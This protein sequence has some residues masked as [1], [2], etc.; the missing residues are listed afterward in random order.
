MLNGEDLERIVQKYQPNFIVPE[1]EAI[2]TEKLLE[3]EQRG[4]TVNL[5]CT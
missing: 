2:R 5:N 3:L 1:I 4:Y